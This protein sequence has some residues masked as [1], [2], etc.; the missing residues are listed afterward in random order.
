MRRFILVLVLL[1]GMFVATASW[2]VTLDNF[3]EGA[4][5]LT[6]AYI[7]GDEQTGLSTDNVISGTRAVVAFAGASALATASLV[8]TAGDDAAEFSATEAL[9]EDSGVLFQYVLSSPIDLAAGGMDRVRVTYTVL[10]GAPDVQVRVTGG[11]GTSEISASL[12]G[13]G[14]ID[15]AYADFSVA[16]STGADFSA[17]DRIDLTFLT[18]GSN[19]AEIHIADF[20]AI[21][22]T[23]PVPT[24]PPGGLLGLF[25]SMSWIFGRTFRTENYPT[26]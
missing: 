22:D 15:F 25:L 23:V 8:L 10:D 5:S 14:S 16:E 26:R 21:A 18:T 19:A 3:E 9:A 11:G 4:F 2:A 20:S 1:S 17:V 12:S 6:T 24:V 7:E 13:D